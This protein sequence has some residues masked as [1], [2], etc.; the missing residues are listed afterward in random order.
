MSSYLDLD[1]CVDGH[2]VAEA[3]L[4]ELR[5]ANIRQVDRLKML[6]DWLP[7]KVWH[8]FVRE[9]PEA[10]QWFDELGEPT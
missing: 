8:E 4:D 6:A 5:R 7:I 9:H 1:D 3:E 10:G 2:V